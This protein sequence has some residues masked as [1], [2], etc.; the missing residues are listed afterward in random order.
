MILF[1]VF[2]LFSFFIFANW[3]Y[4]NIVQ[5]NSIGN[6]VLRAKKGNWDCLCFGSTMGQWAI[7]FADTNVN[8]YN[9]CVGPQF[10]PYSEKMLH[11]YTKYLKPGGTV[12]FIIVDLVFGSE[13]IG[14]YNASEIYSRIL[15][16]KY[17]GEEY[18]INNDIKQNYLPLLYKPYLINN[19]IKSIL[20]KLIP[21]HKDA[22]FMTLTEKDIEDSA[23]IFTRAWINDFKLKDMFSLD[24]PDSMVREFDKT[25]PYL[26]RMIQYCIDNGYKPIL[27]VVPVSGALNNRCGKELMNR[28]LYQNIV[29]ANVQNVPFLD[30]QY[31][32]RFQD[33][34]YYRNSFSMNKKGRDEFTKVLIHDIINLGYLH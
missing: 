26:T 13:G 5:K 28:V 9:L 15:E 16:K 4:L 23:E 33:K 27:T 2:F 20:L 21:R 8:A 32:F 19:V 24:L 1:V 12:I 22:Q 14:W 29:E 6:H 25:K 3:Y 7:D 10:L 17:L 11:Q 34:K 30:Y 31:D 18:S